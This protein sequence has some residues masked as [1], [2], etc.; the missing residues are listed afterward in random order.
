M[1]EMLRKTL[2][3][4]PAEILP[5]W[6]ADLHLIITR[7]IKEA[8]KNV[9]VTSYKME[10]KKSPKARRINELMSQLVSAN[11]RGVDVEI[12]LNSQENKKATSSINWY[13]AKA[14]KK[15]NLSPRYIQ[16]G[17]I[18]HAKIIII[19]DTLTIIGSHNWSVQ[20]H[21]RNI[22][23]SFMVRSKELNKRLTE[24]YIMFWEQSA[25]FPPD[26]G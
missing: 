23:L 2:Q 26:R 15:R 24:K 18:L 10:P 5:L 25:G 12:L 17:R 16:S 13:A 8:K 7:E 22:E 20:S 3:H 4:Y 14:L 1:E 11:N 19:D 21:N 9:F 6:D